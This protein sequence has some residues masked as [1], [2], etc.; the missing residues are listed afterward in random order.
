MPGNANEVSNE[1]KADTA[2]VVENGNATAQATVCPRCGGIA[3]LQLAPNLWRCTSVL[4]AAGPNLYPPSLGVLTPTLAATCGFEYQEASSTNAEPCSCGTDSIGTCRAC[5]QRVCGL[6]SRIVGD[7]R[8]CQ[9]HAQEEEDRAQQCEDAAFVAL[10]QTDGERFRS[11][12]R[13]RIALIMDTVNARKDH[14]EQSFVLVYYIYTTAN[15][16]SRLNVL[17]RDERWDTFEYRATTHGQI[18]QEEGEKWAASLLSGRRP[19]DFSIIDFTSTSAWN[20]GFRSGSAWGNWL[21]RRVGAP[22]RRVRRYSGRARLFS[23]PDDVVDAW[24]AGSRGYMSDAG[25]DNPSQDSFASYLTSQCADGILVD[26]VGR[27]VSKSYGRPSTLPI[28]RADI[29]SLATASQLDLSTLPEMERFELP[30]I[31][32]RKIQG[33][34]VN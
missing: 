11:L 27:D 7:L 23:R 12:L 9:V 29:Q 3:R 5:S 25:S 21:R 34:W 22:T 6:H 26:H 28:Y 17:R 10:V 15:E 30:Y 19:D 16:L 13:S 1:L 8:Y 14:E 32:G 20:W 18:A 33:V 24:P 31:Q 2:P 4:T